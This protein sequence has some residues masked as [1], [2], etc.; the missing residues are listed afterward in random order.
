[1][2]K[3]AFTMIELIFVIVVL[4]ILASIAVPRFAATRDDAIISKGRAQVASIRSAIMTEHQRGILQGQT[5]L[6][7]ELD[8]ATTDHENEALFDGNSSNT[9]LS[10][11]LFS[12]QSQGYWFRTADTS[13]NTIHNYDFY[14]DTITTERF[15]YN[16]TSQLFDCNHNNANC[17]LL[18]E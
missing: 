9:L 10:Y 17:R 8:D 5:D 13:A 14:I 18:A 12:R 4:G 1:M 7:R 15:E 16:I 11:A 3:S 6:P 2:R